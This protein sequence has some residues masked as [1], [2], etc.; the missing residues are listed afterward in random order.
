[1][2]PDTI[3]FIVGTVFA[4]VMVLIAVYLLI[5]RKRSRVYTEVLKQESERFDAITATLLLEKAPPVYTEVSKYGFDPNAIAGAYTIEREIAGGAMSRTFQVRSLKLGNPWF[6][7]FIPRQYGGLANEVN[8]L[9][10]LNH[11]SL[12]RIIDVFH[13]EEGVYLIETLVEGV[14]LDKVA[15]TGVKV[16]QYVLIDWFEQIAQALNYLHSMKPAP[17]FHLD[18]KPGNIMVTHDNRLVLVDFGIARRSGED[19]LGAVTASYAAPE[20]FGG[21]TPEKHAHL[22]HARFGGAHINAGRAGIDAR[23]DLYSL[24]VIM[25]EIATGKIPTLSNIDMLR[26]TVSDELAAIIRKCLAIDPNERFQSADKLLDALR[27]VKGTKLKMARMLFT[28][29]LAAVAASLSFFISGGMFAGGYYIYNEESAAIIKAQPEIVTVSLQ[30]SSDFTVRKEL[31][32]GRVV[33]LDS[34]QIIWEFSENNIARIDGNRVSGINEG[35]TVIRGLYRNKEVGLTVR[36]VRPAD[37]LIEISQRYE[38]GRM[39]SR[40]AGESGRSR[41]DGPIE[42]ANFM[43]PES[44]TLASDGTIYI[45]DA[46]EIRMI[47]DGTVSTIHIPVDYIKAAKIR[48]LDNELYILTE[49]WQD[50]DRYSYAMARLVGANPDAGPGA[51][52]LVEAI[53]IADALYTA[54]EDFQPCDDGMLYFIDRNEGLGGV[55]LRAL[56]L[57][58]VKDIK[59]L[60]TLPH[61]S[62]SIAVTPGGDIYIGNTDT[63]VILIYRNGELKYFAGIE[64]ERAFIDGDS[65]RFYSPQR[66]EYRSGYLYI[67]DFNTLRRLE[68]Q[69]GIAGMCITLAGMADPNFDMENYE[70]RLPA[71]DAVLPFSNLMDFAVTDSGILLTD[72]KRGIIWRIGD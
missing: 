22:L 9:K 33:Y 7:K 34:E 17:I 56:N 30:Q 44:I 51:E 10:Y 70:T 21:R 72:P 64:G 27:M 46:S 25:F 60:A 45:T 3:L 32:D 12:P 71:E 31:A 66:L 65:P 41:T 69:R 6:M 26:N 29:R 37:G 35:E 43:S 2:Y 54:V 14:P 40:F 67:W 36:V 57:F 59:T 42:F 8:I 18:L 47:S 62:T 23:T 39:I 49:F 15:Q 5:S 53:Y 52:T 1:M 63:G 16:S 68:A 48:C 24:G 4:A 11:V 20:Q 58:D 55:F 19:M 61:G 38:Q 13:R 50:G 28:R